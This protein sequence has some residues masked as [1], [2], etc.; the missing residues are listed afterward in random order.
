M[1]LSEAPSPATRVRLVET[2]VFSYVYRRSVRG[3]MDSRLG[4]IGLTVTYLW[5]AEQ[6]AEHGKGSAR[7]EQ[8]RARRRQEPQVSTE[9]NNDNNTFC[10]PMSMCWIKMQ[11]GKA[12]RSIEKE[13][14]T[15][16]EE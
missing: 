2:L 1:L 14:H 12:E 15:T 5:R 13:I 11:Q 3:V 7:H 4:F 8:A 16:L 6:H 9:N 10:T